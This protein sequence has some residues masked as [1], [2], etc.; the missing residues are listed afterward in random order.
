ML[1]MDIGGDVSLL[2]SKPKL[3]TKLIVVV[4]LTLNG[5]GLHLVAFPLITG[6]VQNPRRAATIAAMLGAVSTTSCCTRLLWQYLE[7]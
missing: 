7:S 2:L 1:V 3:L 6:K 5:I 4:A